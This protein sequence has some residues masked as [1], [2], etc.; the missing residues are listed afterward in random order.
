MA[1]LFEGGSRSLTARAIREALRDGSAA[2]AERD[3]AP[4]LS[5][6]ATADEGWDDPVLHQAIYTVFRGLPFRLAAGSSLHV[7]TLDRA[8]GDVEL[9]WEAREVGLPSP[10]VSRPSEPLAQGPLGDLFDLALLGLEEICRARSGVVER[11]PQDPVLAARARV[12]GAVP[13]RFF[14]LIPGPERGLRRG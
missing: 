12:A 3:V 6:E 8:G 10:S 14:F 2:Y 13:R 1:S 9:T 11:T 7:A 5:L 4:L